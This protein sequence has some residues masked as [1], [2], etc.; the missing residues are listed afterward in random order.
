MREILFK[1]KR[2]D[3]GEWVE[4]YL[5]RDDVTGQYF[6]HASGNSVNESDK[7][8][9]EGCL[10]FVAFEIDKDTICQYT[11]LTDKNDNKIWENDVLMFH[12]N[13]NDLAKACYGEFYVIDV[14]TLEKIDSV[15]GW[16]YEV[17]ETDTISKCEPFNIPMPLTNDY[18]ETCELEVIG[19]IFD[20]PELLKGSEESEPTE[21]KEA[22]TK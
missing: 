14:E 3:N 6:I 12:S 10:H 5:L 17:I 4:G 7:V 8:N 18:I 19:N 22:D 15:I 9:E 1:A 21:N 20:N 11:G 16:H 13:K 2:I